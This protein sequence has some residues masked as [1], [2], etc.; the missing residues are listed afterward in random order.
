MALPYLPAR[1]LTLA[2]MAVSFWKLTLS[3]RQA[4]DNTAAE[5]IAGGGGLLNLDELP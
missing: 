5:E 2:G 3:E 4:Q 1:I